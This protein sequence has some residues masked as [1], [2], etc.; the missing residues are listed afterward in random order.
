MGAAGS[1]WRRLRGTG[2]LKPPSLLGLARGTACLEDQENTL[3][4][5]AALSQLC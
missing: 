4:V 2:E 3:S 5:P 1:E